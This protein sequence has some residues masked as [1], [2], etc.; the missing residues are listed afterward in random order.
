MDSIRRTGQTVLHPKYKGSEFGYGPDR[1]VSE[2]RHTGLGRHI[3]TGQP[4]LSGLDSGQLTLQHRRT[5]G[6]V[7]VQTGKAQVLPQRKT[8]LVVIIG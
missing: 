2:T 6:Q 3:E 4:I 5:P 1:K 8:T 7:E